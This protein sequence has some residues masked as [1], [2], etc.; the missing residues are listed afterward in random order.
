[1]TPRWLLTGEADSC[2]SSLHKQEGPRQFSLSR[3]PTASRLGHQEGQNNRQ[4]TEV[5]L[6]SGGG[7]NYA[8]VTSDDL[9]DM[10]TR[11]DQVGD[12]MPP[13]VTRAL[14]VLQ[15][16]NFSDASEHLASGDDHRSLQAG[17]T[18][19]DVIGWRLS[20]TRLSVP[21]LAVAACY[22]LSKAYRC[23]QHVL[24]SPWTLQ[25]AADLLNG[26]SL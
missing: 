18:S 21:L 22:A 10:K 4:V 9:D 1:M 5:N 13:D 14:R 6:I 3:T 2:V 26:D 12:A 7:S 16:P 15:V 17:C 23:R 11:T 19:F 25:E 8:T 24:R 20:L